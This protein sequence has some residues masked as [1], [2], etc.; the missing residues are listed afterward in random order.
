ML[1][2]VAA[3]T[4]QTERHGQIDL[5]EVFRLL[6]TGSMV[7]DDIRRPNNNIKEPGPFKVPVKL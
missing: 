7:E 4:Q 6:A 3:Q 1:S 5:V 2:R